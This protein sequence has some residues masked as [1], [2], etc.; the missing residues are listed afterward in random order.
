[1]SVVR[2]QRALALMTSTSWS[3]ERS[4]ARF[5]G[6]PGFVELASLIVLELCGLLVG[7]CRASHSG[8]VAPGAHRS[9]STE[10]LAAFVCSGSSSSSPGVYLVCAA[11]LGLFVFGE[12]Y[13]PEGAHG[14]LF[15]EIM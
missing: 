11:P 14:Y 10:R 5:D 7:Q 13:P 8:D 3:S 2:Y 4:Y 9:A 1:M 15:H 6:Q 12:A